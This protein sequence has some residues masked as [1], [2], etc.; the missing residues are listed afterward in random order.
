MDDHHNGWRHLVLPIATD[1]SLIMESVLSAVAFHF[2]ANIS[3][4][5]LNSNV[6]YGAAIK[7]LRQRQDLSVYNVYERQIIVLC[8]LV[9]IAAT[10]VNGTSDFRLLFN[11]LDSAWNAAGG[12]Q[13]LVHGELGLFLLRQVLK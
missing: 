12:E 5:L 10:I 2:S 6:L 3:D 1:D 11:L 13:A 9:L 8:L 4:R 7:S